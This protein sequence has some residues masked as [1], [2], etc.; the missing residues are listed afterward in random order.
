MSEG[1]YY[2]R[3]AA[4]SGS[5]EGSAATSNPITVSFYNPDVFPPSSSTPLTYDSWTAGSLTAAGQ[6][7][8]YTFPSDGET[9][10]ISWNDSYDGDHTYNADIRVSAYTSSEV[11]LFNENEEDSGYSTPRQISG[12]YGTIYLKVQGYSSHNV[13]TYAIKYFQG[14]EEEP[15]PAPENLSGAYYEGYEGYVQ[16]TWSYVSGASYY[17]VYRGTSPYSGEYISDTS[18]TSFSDPHLSPGTYYY[19]VV[20]VS[21]S[22]TPGSPATSD[23]ITVGQ[24]PLPDEPSLSFSDGLP[25]GTW[26]VYVASGSIT[27]M[28]DYLNV[29]SNYVA[30]GASTLTNGNA[31]TLVTLGVPGGTFD[32]NGNYVVLYTDTSG[33]IKYQNNV[34]F[35]GG[36]ATIS[37][38]GMSSL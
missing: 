17:R 12:Q 37:F 7:V 26:G 33:T 32:P 24:T 13:G 14:V 6:V 34:S 22:G 36:S 15:L 27:S 25:G 8:W 20:A 23:P 28:M 11:P 16:L 21:S 35:S 5:G 2:Y 10:N 4:V 18:N 9:Y 38:S 3:V 19:Q 1:I 31:A 30:V 29:M